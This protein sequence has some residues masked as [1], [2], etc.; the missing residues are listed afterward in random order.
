MKRRDFITLVGGAVGAAWP[1]AARAQQA[2][3][4]RRIGVLFGGPN[5]EIF[6]SKFSVF[7]QT[8][9]QL[10]WIDGHNIE[11]NIRWGMDPERLMTE[12]DADRGAC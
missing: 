7:Q 12:A 2:E 6:R 4:I 1:L 8:L 9:Q 5:D 3:R 10:S 11:F